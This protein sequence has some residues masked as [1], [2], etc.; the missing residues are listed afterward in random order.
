MIA[1]RLSTIRRADH[2]VVMAHGKI[3]EQG[4][5]EEL[6]Q[7]DGHYALLVAM[8]WQND[9]DVHAEKNLQPDASL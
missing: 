7:Q 9:Q 1:H 6:L 8:D 4:S 5:H 2:I 3:V